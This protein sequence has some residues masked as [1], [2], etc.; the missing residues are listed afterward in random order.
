MTVE[1]IFGDIRNSCGSRLNK[2]N[3]IKSAAA[4]FQAELYHLNKVEAM[5]SKLPLWR[6]F[7]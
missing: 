7:N 1:H 2:A 6:S 3:H 5:F 4:G